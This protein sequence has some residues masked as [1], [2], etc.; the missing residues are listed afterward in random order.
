VNNS[1]PEPLGIVLGKV[2]LG[3]IEFP[4][5]LLHGLLKMEP[6]FSGLLQG[7]G[8]GARL[9]PMRMWRGAEK[10]MFVQIED[11]LKAGLGNAQLSE[12]ARLVQIQVDHAFHERV[13]QKSASR[14]VCPCS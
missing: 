3:Q 9:A 5:I 11:S 1:C 10:E 8:G 12:C 4:L 14:S 13:V 2:E 7:G 6:G